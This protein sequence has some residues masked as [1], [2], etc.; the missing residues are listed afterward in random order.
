MWLRL[1]WRRVYL[2]AFGAAVLAAA[3]VI[4]AVL[5]ARGRRTRGRARADRPAPRLLQLVFRV[6]A[7]AEK[8]PPEWQGS[9]TLAT[10]VSHLGRDPAG[11]YR[12][13]LMTV[14]N[15]AVVGLLLSVCQLVASNSCVP[16][17]VEAVFSAVP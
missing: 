14:A 2:L 12:P 17:T 10:L 11:A 4:R 6:R 15:T 5:E 1:V 13:A 8:R 16:A 7:F 9:L 3:F